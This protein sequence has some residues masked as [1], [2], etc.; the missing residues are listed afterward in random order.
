MR[1]RFPLKTWRS[2]LTY[3]VRWH[4]AVIEDL[5]H[6][7]RQTRKKIVGRV[8]DCLSQDPVGLGKPLKGMFRGVY[9]YR[10]GNYRIIYTVDQED[11]TVMLLRTANRKNV[12]EDPVVRQLPDKKF[13]K[14]TK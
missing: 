6:L 4:E 9:R 3:N 7:D 2:L 12:Y 10:Y 1:S 13:L 11:M 14:N 5:N 8:K